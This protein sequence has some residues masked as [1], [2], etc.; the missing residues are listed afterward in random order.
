[1]SVF[2]FCCPLCKGPLQTSPGSYRCVP[3][4]QT[5]PLLLGIPD[6]RVFVGPHREDENTYKVDDYRHA[7]R[8]VDCFEKLD[9]AGLVRRYLSEAG[10]QGER[11]DRMVRRILA[12]NQRGFDALLEIEA[13]RRTHHGQTLSRL[14]ELGCG[15]GSFLVA[16]TSGV[17]RI[18]GVDMAMRWL[19]LAKK[20]F[21]E[22]NADVSLVCCYAEYLPFESATFDV[23]VAEDFI[24]HVRQ[25]E[26]T[27]RESRRVIRNRGILYL[28]YPNRFS[29]APEPHVRVWGVGFLPRRWMSAYVERV[30]GQ[31]Y[32]HTRLLSYFETKRLL[33]RCRFGEQEISTPPIP[34]EERE[35]FSRW[36]RAGATVYDGLRR[37]AFSRP[38]LFLLGPFFRVLASAIEAE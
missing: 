33:H 31:P 11:F 21:A 35:S 23:I 37:L 28:T 24:E 29:I 34:A 4:A 2:E 12:V 18:V 38:V 27:L 3:C 20:R 19:I 25:Q 22:R 6:F 30:T 32:R 14:L 17:E 16:A 15:S 36:R 9:F 1:M 26:A 7:Q 8:L 13:Y 5:F 10:V